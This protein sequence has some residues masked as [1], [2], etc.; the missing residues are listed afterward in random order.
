MDCRYKRN[1]LALM[2]MSAIVPS[3]TFAA[4]DSVE[5]SNIEVIGTTPLHGVGLPEDMIPT[6]VQT[7]TSEDIEKTQSLDLSEFM[8]RTLGSVNINSAQNNPYQPDV[9][10]RGYS[11]SPL[12]GL[13]QGMSVYMD[14]VRLNA[15]FGDNVNWDTIPQS[16]IA[17]IN[18]MPGSNPLFGLNTL[19]GA[20]SIKSKNGFTHEGHSL[21]AYT[22]SFD[23]HAVEMES[24]GNDGELGYFVTGNWFEEDGSRDH[25][26]SE[27]RQLF[28]NTSWRSE[29]STL[30]LSLTATDNDLN[31]NGASPV[32]LIDYDRD[33]VFTW[34]DKTENE[35]QLVNLQGS[36][37]VNDL[38]LASGNM[39][40]RHNKTKSFNGDGTEFEEGSGAD[41]GFLVDEDG[42][43][44]QDQNG[45]D[46]PD[47]I[48]G[49]ELSAINNRGDITENSGGLGFQ[50]TFLNDLMGYENQL[51]TG[52]SYDKGRTDYDSSVEVS[53][54]TETRGTTKT[55]VFSGDDF[56]D[57]KAD[58][59]TYSFFFTDTISITDALA[60]TLSGRYNNTEI[61]MKDKIDR[62]STINATHEFHRFNPAAGLTFIV[63]ESVSTYVNYSES[64]RAP[65]PSEL[66]CSDPNDPCKLPNAFL[67]DPPLDQVVAKSWEGGLRGT[68]MDDIS[69]NA[70]LFTATNHDDIMFISTG[71]ATGNTGFFDNIGETRRQGA[72]LGISGQHNKLSWAVNYSYIEAEFRSALTMSSPNNPTADANGD[73]H[74]KSG[75]S[76]PGIPKHN[77]KLG[78]DYD[79]TTKFSMGVDAIV[80]SEQYYRG[81]ESNDLG[82]ISGYTVV[83]LHTDYQVTPNIKFFAKVDNLFDKDYSNFGL[84]GEP[85]EIFPT[86]ND[87]RFE[88]VGAPR[89]GWVGVKVSM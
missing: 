30:D 87:P 84:L 11:A 77:L 73:I 25:S 28:T 31:G 45:N 1:T 43:R 80:N 85:D 74:V 29:T 13:P 54:L 52:V 60:L 53:S 9:T 89:A 6:N 8:N 33:A 64:S 50:L 65:T 41:S 82:Q 26:D 7:A 38:T 72:E 81:D 79:F 10:Y 40:Y 44:V 19:G 47:E 46:I 58:N 5:L 71:G 16:A 39:Y 57:V 56:V 51:V 66:G 49:E 35:M 62:A 75:D 17:S 68:I 48:N 76:M 12:L 78:T 23:R 20:L 86:F 69:W 37:W 2:L 61:K 63:N 15:P 22:G 14:G 18:L 21:Q 32:E 34:P 27:V 67:A 36:H 4:E 59:R 42:D 88:G 83:N 24:G 3:T 55:G 70:G